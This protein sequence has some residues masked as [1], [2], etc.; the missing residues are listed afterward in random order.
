LGYQAV[1]KFADMSNYFV[2]VTDG[3]MDGWMYRT[4]AAYAILA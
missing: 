4:A 1:T 2:S 3:Y